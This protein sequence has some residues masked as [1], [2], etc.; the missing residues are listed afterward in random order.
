MALGGGL[1]VILL[2]H[3]AAWPTRLLYAVLSTALTGLMYWLLIL[4]PC[5]A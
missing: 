2:S 3:D 1:F 5:T 4:A